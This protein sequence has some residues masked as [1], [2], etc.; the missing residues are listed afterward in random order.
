[1]ELDIKIIMIANWN[2]MFT[3]VKLADKTG[4]VKPGRPRQ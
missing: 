1:M 2:Q 3:R 4:R